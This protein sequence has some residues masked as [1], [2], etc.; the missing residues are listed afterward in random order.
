VTGLAAVAGVFTLVITQFVNDFPALSDQ[1]ARG[2]KQIQDWLQTGFLHLTDKQL[3]G[4][5]DQIQQ[6]LSNNKD[7]LSGAALATAST[8][9][10][11]LT[12]LFLVLFA[13]FFFLR[14]GRKISRFMVGLLPEQARESVAYAADESWGT[15]VSYVRATVL[16]AFIDAVGIGLALVILRVEAALPLAALV[17]IGAFIPIIGAALSGLVASLVALVTQGPLVALLVIAAVVAVQQLEGHVL[18]PLI[19]GRAV[20]IH[21]LAVI[22]AIA[23]GVVLAGIIGALV[24][25]PIVAMLNTGVRHLIIAR[26]ASGELPATAAPNLPPE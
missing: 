18:Q 3:N 17:F 23:T 15:L 5:L 10:H 25:V 22:L 9:A 11:L 2:V 7:T 16:V 14:D 19:M 13:T 12:G 21:P 4:V 26:R 6:W 24:A 1:T 8:L 20:A